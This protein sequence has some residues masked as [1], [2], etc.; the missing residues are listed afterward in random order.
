MIPFLVASLLVIVPFDHSEWDRFL[1]KFVNEKGEVNYLAAHKESAL[2]DAYLT[3]LKQ[4]PAGE[5]KGWPR[6]EKIAVLINAYNAGIIKLILTHYPVKTVMNI[7]GFWDQEAIELGTPRVYSLNQIENEE[8]RKGFRDEKILFALS[9]GA[10]GSPRLR[11]EAYTSLHLE[12]QLYLATR[13]FA[14]DET[15][16]QIEPGKKK[17]HLS[18]LFKWYADDFLLNWGNF[19]EGNKWD[20]EETAVLSFFAHYLEDSKKVEYLKEGE[21]K[22]GYSTFDWHLNEWSQGSD[23]TKS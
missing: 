15:K 23:K 16:N 20:P 4:I 22:V 9:K 11:Q 18:K 14:N 10:K 5:F 21:Y 2:L 13:E 17:L 6:E 7:P 19:P 8:L 3:K 1:K 12:G